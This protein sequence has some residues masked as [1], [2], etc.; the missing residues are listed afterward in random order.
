MWENKL[1]FFTL[2]LLT[3]GYE[4]KKERLEYGHSK[5][6]RNNKK[7]LENILPNLAKYCL[8]CFFWSV[9]YY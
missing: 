6:N 1:I 8:M 2:I 3:K 4:G 9:N 5:L 7:K